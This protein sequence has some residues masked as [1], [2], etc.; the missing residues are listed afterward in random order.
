MQEQSTEM[1]QLYN[2]LF[3]TIDTIGHLRTLEKFDFTIAPLL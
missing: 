3:N 1:I 2:L